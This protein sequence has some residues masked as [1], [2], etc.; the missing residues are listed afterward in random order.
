MQAT[1]GDVVLFH[2]NGRKITTLP[3]IVLVTHGGDLDEIDL[4]V[5]VKPGS[6]AASDLGGPF[7]E[8]VP[9]TDDEPEAGT[10]TWPEAQ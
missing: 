8:S 7:P 2:F 10:W 6:D 9:F 5:F 1:V 4:Q 3:A